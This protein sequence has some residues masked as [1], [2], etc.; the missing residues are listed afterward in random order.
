[1]ARTSRRFLFAKKFA[2]K[3]GSAHYSDDDNNHESNNKSTFPVA[4]LQRF[5]CTC[6]VDLIAFLNVVDGNVASLG[7]GMLY[8]AARVDAQAVRPVN[9]EEE[10]LVPGRR[11]RESLPKLQVIAK[12]HQEQLLKS[13]NRQ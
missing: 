7:H 6:Q 5:G 4:C 11:A 12:T 13:F 1:M 10:V 2:N 8:L 3:I 9:L